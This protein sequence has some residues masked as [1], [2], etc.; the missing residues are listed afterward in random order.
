MLSAG[1]GASERTRA[2][3]AAR[4]LSGHALGSLA[5]DAVRHSSSRMAARRSA[6]ASAPLPPHSMRRFR[7]A[8]LRHVRR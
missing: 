6:A 8:S 2:T 1:A 3:A 5:A 4:D 7:C